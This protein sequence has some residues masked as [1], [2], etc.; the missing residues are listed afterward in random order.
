MVVD[1][2]VWQ[3]LTAHVLDDEIMAVKASK[4]RF[5][6]AFDAEFGL[7]CEDTELRHTLATLARCRGGCKGLTPLMITNEDVALRECLS[8]NAYNTECIVATFNAIAKPN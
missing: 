4:K 8:M 7:N 6:K 2:H 1:F 5:W 3:K